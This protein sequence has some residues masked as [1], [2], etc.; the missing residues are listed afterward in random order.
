MSDQKPKTK[1]DE[2]RDITMSQYDWINYKPIAKQTTEVINE[3]I[4][5]GRTFD[6]VKEWKNG[7]FYHLK[8]TYDLTDA[9]NKLYKSK[10]CEAFAVCHTQ[11]AM[12]IILLTSYEYTDSEDRIRDANHYVEA[13]S[14]VR[15][16]YN[17]EDDCDDNRQLEMLQQIMEH[18]SRAIYGFDNAD[19]KTEYCYSTSFF[20]ADVYLNK[21]ETVINKVELKDYS[22]GGGSLEVEKVSKYSRMIQE[23]IYIPLYIEGEKSG[24]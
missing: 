2:L 22:V 16:K 12:S 11:G 20:K 17:G 8:E 18:G 7:D 14:A 13:Y 23:M 19:G 6:G 15:E 24:W 3:M 5:Y 10:T 9:E 1:M 4:P 21:G